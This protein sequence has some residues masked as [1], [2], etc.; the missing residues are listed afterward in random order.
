MKE[1]QKAPLPKAVAVD[2]EANGCCEILLNGAVIAS[3]PNRTEKQCENAV[4]P[5]GGDSYNRAVG[6]S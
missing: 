6:P 2:V 4:G 1:T 5:N 3:L